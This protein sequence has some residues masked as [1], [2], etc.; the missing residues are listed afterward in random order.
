MVQPVSW[1]VFLVLHENNPKGKAKLVRED[2]GEA[3]V[4][5]IWFLVHYHCKQ[6]GK[7]FTKV[8]RYLNTPSSIYSNI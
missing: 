8:F 4:T 2:K 1:L 7:R 5:G 3:L 6:P